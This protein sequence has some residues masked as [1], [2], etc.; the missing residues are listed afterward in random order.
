M[1]RYFFLALFTFGIAA[2]IVAFDWPVLSRDITATFGEYR[3]NHFHNGI[4][5]GGGE[6]DVYPI[7]DGEVVFSFEE[8]EYADD[9]PTGLG[10]FIILEHAGKIR[11]AYDHLMTGSMRI[12]T[13]E[14]A[15]SEPLG[16]LGATGF[17][18]GPHLHL[19]IMDR[20][21]GRTINPLLI[22]PALSDNRAPIIGGTAL[23]SSGGR[24]PLH[25]GSVIPSG[26]VE[27]TAQVYDPRPT[28]NFFWPMAPY[29]INVFLNGQQV[30][31]LTCDSLAMMDGEDTLNPS[32][33][34]SF[35]NFYTSPDI[36]SLGH[37]ELPPGKAKIEIEAR[38]FVDNRNV[39]SYTFDVQDF[40]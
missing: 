4:D 25:E 27:L 11:S 16:K 26:E 17:S 35:S 29:R 36:V 21:L 30:F 8:N 7:A 14:I 5:I 9:I 3:G 37:F 19:Q 22:L 15:S 20:E 33:D 10:S 13:G 2:F 1:K 40:Q 23:I 38:D 32:S 18:E 24:I 39:I 34:V 28:V 6:Q 12:R 31:Q